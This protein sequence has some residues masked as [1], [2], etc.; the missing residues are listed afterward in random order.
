MQPCLSGE[1]RGAERQGRR[2]RDR[3]H[4]QQ[5]EHGEDQ[6]LAAS[7]W[8]S[9]PSLSLKMNRQC[10]GPSVPTGNPETPI[11]PRSDNFAKVR[12]SYGR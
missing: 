9:A 11:R 1:D 7:L 12:L 4:A 8:G 5:R 6:P 2:S 3:S 10:L